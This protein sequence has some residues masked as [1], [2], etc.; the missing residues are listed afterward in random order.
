MAS[1]YL[2]IFLTALFPISEVRGAIPLG[3]IHYKLPLAG[4]VSVAVAG[5]ML[6]VIVFL[7]I[8]PFIEAQ[9]KKCGFTRRL[10]DRLFTYTRKRHEERFEIYKELALAIFVAIPLPM[11]GAWSGM[12]AAYVFGIPFW[13]GTLMIFIGVLIASLIVTLASLGIINFILIK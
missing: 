12:I 11:T 9:L 10:L 7:K 8:F 4:V 13:R 5:N 6:P 1:H 2:N 3:L